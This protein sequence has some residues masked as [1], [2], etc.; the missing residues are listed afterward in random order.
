MFFT[1]KL[2]KC[3]GCCFLIAKIIMIFE[4]FLAIILCI[5]GFLFLVTGGMIVNV[6]H[7]QF[8]MYNSATFYAEIQ[9]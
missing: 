4:S 5:L 1:H 8:Q 6:C 3:K 2:E 9:P 7:Y